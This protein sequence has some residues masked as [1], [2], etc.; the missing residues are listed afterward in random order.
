MS[1]DNH[2][3]GQENDGYPE[4]KDELV[5]RL[6]SMVSKMK[7]GVP[8]IRRIESGAVDSNEATMC[9]AFLSDE[10]TSVKFVKKQEDS[11]DLL[12]ISHLSLSDVEEVAMSK[13]D[14][15]A[16]AL[17]IP[18]ENSIVELIFA[19][20]ED[21]ECWFYGLKILCADD[22]VDSTN[23]E[24][25]EIQDESL[26]TSP[27]PV[28]ELVELVRELQIQNSG[29]KEVLGHCQSLIDDLKDRADREEEQR[30]HT[31]NEN[32]KLVKLL[33]VRDETIGELSNLVQSLITKQSSLVSMHCKPV[34]SSVPSSRR[35]SID[36]PRLYKPADRSSP[37]TTAS[38]SYFEGTSVLDGLESQLKKLDER[39][40]Q[41]ELL[42]GSVTTTC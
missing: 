1:L 20:E 33:V 11:P 6:S 32:V 37:A 5:N 16:I 38:S 13:A 19:S 2:P 24:A 21:L 8:L 27:S 18:N 14:K 17:L 23:S 12:A 39:K 10:L 22:K 4:L 28:P 7:E 40:K 15:H 9:M 41:L 35:V 31:E 29:L 3:Q 25:T 30:I 26:A 34:S 42:L 36:A